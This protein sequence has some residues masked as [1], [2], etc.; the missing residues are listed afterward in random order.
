MKLRY[1]L[2][3]IV[4]L[5]TSLSQ[6]QTPLA[7]PNTFTNGEIIDADKINQNFTEVETR[8]NQNQGHKHLYIVDGNDMVLGELFQSDRIL[9]LDSSNGE[10]FVSDKGYIGIVTSVASDFIGASFNYLFQNSDCSGEPLWV[11]ATSTNSLLPRLVFTPTWSV[12]RYYIISTTVE[13]VTFNS[14]ITGNPEDIA[15]NC[16]LN[17]DNRSAYSISVNA[18]IITGVPDSIQLPVR[19]EYK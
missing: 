4:A 6:A 5:I 11:L 12:N 7:I 1:S 19:L 10:V 18:P 2:A 8:I 3:L 16:V 17:T 15:A 14:H 13:T 9:N